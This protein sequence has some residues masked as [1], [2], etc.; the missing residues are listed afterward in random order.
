VSQ[1]LQLAKA[2]PSY[3]AGIQDTLEQLDLGVGGG[4]LSDAVDMVQDQVL[5]TL[6]NVT[7]QLLAG[8]LGMLAGLGSVIVDGVLILIIS[9]YMV[10]G[11]RQ[12]HDS[13]HGV[14]HAPY[15]RHYLFVTGALILVVGGYIRSQLALALLLGVVVTIGMALLGL[16]YALLLGVFALILGLIPMFGSALSAVPALLVAL[17]MPWPTVV[18]V[19]IFFIV[20]QNV[21]DQVLAPR[22]QGEAVGLHPLAVMFALLAGAQVAGAI[23]ALFAVPL[24]A[25]VWI[26]IVAIYRNY[27]GR[28]QGSTVAEPAVTIDERS[29]A[30]TPVNVQSP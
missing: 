9:I 22:I 29:A 8:F 23:G 17:T 14:L 1:A 25:L 5:T 12:I 27:V 11:G 21:Q 30:E 24:A 10:I 3:I 26:V 15:D 2:L 20:V 13:M 28:P 6:A 7:G 18:W 4:M 16:P 19:G